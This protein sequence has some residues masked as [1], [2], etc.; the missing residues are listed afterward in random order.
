MKR[1]C[2]MAVMAAALAGCSVG[3]VGPQASLFDLGPA[4]TDVRQLPPRGPV[5]LQYSAVA[6][7]NDSG[8]IWRV[9]DSTAPRAYAGY[10]W[11][12]APAALVR[13]RLQERL[14]QE[15]PV[16]SDGVGLSAPQLRLTLTRFEQV[17]AADGNSSQAQLALQAVLIQDG[18]VLGQRRFA[19]Q[20]PAQ[21]QDAP[22]GVNALRLATD[23]AG[24]AIAAWL[25]SVMPPAR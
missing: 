22:G 14:S 12:D 15:G 5:I 6:P 16:L 7:L 24:D 20:E 8:V 1:L 25:A 11:S 21:S 4:K 10:R 18:K 2:L 13:Q 3:K 17:F 23:Q 19:Y 9:G